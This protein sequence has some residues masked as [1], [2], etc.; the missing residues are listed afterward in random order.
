MY[1][2]LRENIENTLGEKLSENDFKQFCILLK[3]RVFSK[4]EFLA[5]EGKKCDHL[6]FIERGSCY[7]YITNTKGDNHV[8]QFALEGYWISDLYSFFSGSKGIYIISC[9]EECS[10]MELSKENFDKICDISP[11]F[12]RFFRLLIQ[13][14]YVAMQYRLIKTTSDEAE[15]RYEEFSK[16]HPKFAQRVPQYLIA[17]YL[18]IRPQSLSR[19]RK[20]I[21]HKR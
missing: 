21:A 18:G 14:A 5:E 16:L 15:A 2:Q 12:D 6:Y 7:S 4:G 13:K 19:I 17:S 3:S 11:V 9:L 20:D 10:V 8:V 1:I